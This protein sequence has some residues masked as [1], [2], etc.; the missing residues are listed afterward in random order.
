MVLN[1]DGSSEPEQ[2]AHVWSK[3]EIRSVNDIC[4]HQQK[5]KKT[6]THCARVSR[7]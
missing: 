4:L 5:T 3:T 2:I 7:L 1:S 6:L